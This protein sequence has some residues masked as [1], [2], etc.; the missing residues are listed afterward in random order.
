MSTSVS[1]IIMQLGEWAISAGATHVRA[2][3]QEYFLTR[4]SVL[5]SCEANACGKYGRCWMCP[6]KIGTLDELSARLQCYATGLLIQNVA[7]LEDSWDFEGMDAA[8]RAHN[9]MI[10]TL[11]AQVRATFPDAEVLPLGCGSCGYCEKCCCPDTPCR[12]PDQAISSV[13][14]YGMDVKALVESCGLHYI[15]GVNTVSYVGLILLR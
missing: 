6:P 14:G 2:A 9:T 4:P 12:F 7:T 1:T 10:R 5:A 8:M 3:Q 11:G 13:E 15:N